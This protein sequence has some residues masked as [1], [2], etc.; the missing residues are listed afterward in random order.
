MNCSSFN[1]P[2]FR[3]ST[4]NLTLMPIHKLWNVSMI[5]W[6]EESGSQLHMIVSLWNV[7]MQNWHTFLMVATTVQSCSLRLCLS[8]IRLLH[9]AFYGATTFYPCSNIM[10]MGMPA[11]K[12]KLRTSLLDDLSVIFWTFYDDSREC[13]IILSLSYKSNPC[14]KQQK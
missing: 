9:T 6:L 8:P 13:H 10:V 2:F 4:L 1:N 5:L 14:D 3:S 7:K 12:Q 11:L